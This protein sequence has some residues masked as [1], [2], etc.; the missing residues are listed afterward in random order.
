METI[1]LWRD[2]YIYMCVCVDGKR[3]VIFE[4]YVK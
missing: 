1:S 3:E 4:N 2:I